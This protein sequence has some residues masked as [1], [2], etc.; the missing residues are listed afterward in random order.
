MNSEET[1]AV[2]ER[3]NY[4]VA[5]FCKAYPMSKAKLYQYWAMG[6]GPEYFMVGNRRLIPASE[7]AWRPGLAREKAA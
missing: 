2:P 4:T 1:P 3:F 5:G 6:D 7:R